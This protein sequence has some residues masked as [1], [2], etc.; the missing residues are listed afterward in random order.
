MTLVNI[1]SKFW[2]I[3]DQSGPAS[4]GNKALYYPKFQYYWSLIIRLISVISR[5]LVARVLPLCI[6]AAGVFFGLNRLGQFNSLWIQIVCM[7]ISVSLHP[8]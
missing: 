3:Q 4:D 5:T 8:H 7:C 6:E 1:F 2:T